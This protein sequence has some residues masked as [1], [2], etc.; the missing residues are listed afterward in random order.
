MRVKH[1]IAVVLVLGAVASFQT[2]ALTSDSDPQP[3]P[4]SA[5]A[6]V[7]QRP[8]SRI[9]RSASEA[10][11][12]AVARTENRPEARFGQTTDE[13]DLPRRPLTVTPS[14]QES[15]D[16]DTLV[17][18]FQKGLSADTRE[19]AVMAAGATPLSAIPALGTVIVSINEVDREETIAHLK[20]NILVD[21]VESNRLRYVMVDANDE[22]YYDQ[23]HILVS[24]LPIAWEVTK[25]STSLD[26]AILDTGIDLDHPDLDARIMAPRDIVNNDSV[27]QDEN[28]HGTMVAGI[29]AAETNNGIGVSGAAWN[30]RIMPV[31]VLDA[32]GG[33]DSDIASGIIWAVDHGAEVINMSLGGPG[34]STLLEDAVAYATAHNVIVVAASGNEATTVPSYPAAIPDVVAVG[35]TDLNGD[36]TD[37][38]NYG[39]WIDVVAPGTDIV[40]TVLTAGT[41]GDYAIGDGTSF[42]SPIVAGVA[43]LIKAVNPTWTPAQIAGRLTSSAAD[44]GPDGIDDSYGFGLL[45]AYAAVGGRKAASPPIAPAD[46]FE[47]NDLPSNAPT[48]TSHIQPTISPEGDVDWYRATVAT[49]GSIILNVT[50]LGAP[51]RLGLDAVVETFTPDLVSLGLLNDK[52]R[53]GQEIITIPAPI[54]GS[55]FFRV[56]VTEGSRG[57]A[58]YTFHAFVSTDQLPDGPHGEQVWI[59]SSSPPNRST[60]VAVGKKP[61][62]TFAREIDPAS[63]NTSTTKLLD[64]ETR[65]VVPASRTFDPAARTLTLTPYKAL[66][67]GHPYLV[68]IRGVRDMTGATMSSEFRSRFTVSATATT[69]THA[70]ING[71]V[72]EDVVVGVPG[73]TVG[74]NASAGAVHVMYGGRFGPET[75]GSQVWT[76]N[77]GGVADT[78]E[79]GD[80]FG[81]AVAT[82]DVNN[83]GYDDVAVGVPGEDLG[84]TR[85]AGL[86]HL[87]LG[88]ST[89]LRASGSQVW[90]QDS[91]G[92]PDAAEF[93]DKFGSALAF[94]DFDNVAGDDLA[95][96]SPSEKVGTAANAGALH[97]LSGRS[98]GLTATGA[99]V[100]TQTSI[101]GFDIPAASFG[102]SLAAGDFD[103]DTHD[104]LAVGAP[105]DDINLGD[106]GSVTLLRGTIVGLRPAGTLWTE[107][108]QHTPAPAGERFGTALA[109][110]DFGGLADP[111]GFADL[112]IGVPGISDGAGRVDVAFGDWLGAGALVRTGWQSGNGNQ[113]EA[114]DGFG[115]ALSAMRDRRSPSALLAI[116]A[117]G[118][119]LGSATDAGVVHIVAPSDWVNNPSPTVPAPYSQNSGGV[120]DVAESG[121]RFGAAV[122]LLDVDANGIADLLIGS[123][124]EGLGP[125]PS[126]G[127]AFVL[128]RQSGVPTVQQTIYIYQGKDGT[129]GIA[130]ARDWFGAAL[131]G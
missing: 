19:A 121:D 129:P 109:I 82:G 53:G 76:Q 18:H 26:I 78:A 106:E 24:R 117:P 7:S 30:A 28:G 131:A 63:V 41:G 54:V 74:S 104:D 58:P 45:D 15:V 72:Y 36:L 23:L 75:N 91:S 4:R 97:A 1:G 90:T 67:R 85:D 16:P 38:S 32:S 21:D 81:T 33:L 51:G 108:F 43:L 95:I 115:S 2:Y 123:P 126:A 40:S 84:G 56:S 10:S 111:D 92:V 60:G 88:S 48:V 57:P 65:A 105:R 86:V 11:F 66:T 112:A 103:G 127:A 52:G 100:F 64:G 6:D 61:V 101:Y 102:A 114:G 122:S 37:F 5:G 20:Q 119:D 79:A 22:L 130:R 9:D 69:P 3:I 118:E 107:L 128:R 99:K 44:R 70:D 125:N 49:P 55:Y 113:P 77:T 71:D 116:G 50:P 94:G 46:A 31:K 73:E 42:S 120:P 47:P 59:R 27:P 110:A 12:T 93:G 8:A 34:E 62:I 80:N 87:F 29:A 25:G 17:V 124:N 39:P 98:T 14:D 35:A 96:G 89:G 13:S 68:D 83:D